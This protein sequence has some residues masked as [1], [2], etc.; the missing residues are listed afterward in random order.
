MAVSQTPI[1]IPWYRPSSYE[2][3][4]N[5]P[6]C[7][8]R[9]EFED[10]EIRARRAFA[11]LRTTGRPVVQV[12]LEPGDVHSYMS[13]R[14]TGIVSATSRAEIAN[15]KLAASEELP[16]LEVSI[17]CPSCRAAYVFP[18]GVLGIAAGVEIGC[19]CGL[20]LQGLAPQQAYTPDA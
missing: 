17:E 6:G 2:Q 20:T 14:G 10:W 18:G 9:E 15:N 7:D 4:R 1:A 8:L 19:A 5:I 12:L 3:I 11:L 16:F 13:E